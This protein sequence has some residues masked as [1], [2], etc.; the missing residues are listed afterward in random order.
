MRPVTDRPASRVDGWELV[1]LLGQGAMGVQIEPITEMASMDILPAIW[2][3]LRSTVDYAL[4][5][6]S[7]IHI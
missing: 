4:L 2:E 3:G 1:E 7:L 5:V 6:L